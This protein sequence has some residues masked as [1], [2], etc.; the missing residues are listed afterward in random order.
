MKYNFLILAI[1]VFLFTDCTII[2]PLGELQFK[3]DI[4][5]KSITCTQDQ[6]FTLQMDVH[7][8]GGY[9]WF[10]IISD[11][12]IVQLDNTKFDYPHPEGFVGGNSVE[13]F[14]FRAKSKGNCK[15]T[16]EEK[17]SWEK[18]NAPIKKIQFRVVVN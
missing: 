18:K 16:L 8:D 7:S 6:V 11:E 15:I 4:N 5:G 14:Y 2:L 17:R 10:H 1:P 9:Q 12:N 13:T 3:E